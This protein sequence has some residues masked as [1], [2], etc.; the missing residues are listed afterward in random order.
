M[1]SNKIYDLQLKVKK[2][3]VSVQ[4]RDYPTIGKQKLGTD[5]LACGQEIK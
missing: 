4:N 5:C 3:E 2:S 1:L